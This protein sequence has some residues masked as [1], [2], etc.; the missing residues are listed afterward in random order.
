VTAQCLANR[1][2]VIT[3]PVKLTIQFY[4]QAPKSARKHNG[5][6]PHPV[7]PDTDNLLKAVMDAMT[8]VQVWMDDA[9]VYSSSAGKFYTKGKTGARIK[10]EVWEAL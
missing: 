10:V 5:D 7:K 3:Q 1:K 6:Y 9:Q 8:Q 2:P 4:F